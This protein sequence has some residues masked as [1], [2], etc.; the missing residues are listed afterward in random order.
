L[1]KIG[2]GKG[3]RHMGGR[4]AE[5]EEESKLTQVDTDTTVSIK[6]N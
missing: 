6:E 4:I 5:F 1:N 3:E 2:K